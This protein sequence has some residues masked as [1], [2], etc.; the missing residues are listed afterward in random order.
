MSEG[1]NLNE[2]AEADLSNCGSPGEIAQKEAW[3]P[4]AWAV[5]VAHRI[6]DLSRPLD[7]QR[8]RLA[9]LVACGGRADRATSES[10]GQHFTVLEALFQRFTIEALRVVE[11]GGHKAPEHSEA[12]MRSALKAQRAALAC[13]S[14]LKSLRSDDVPTKP[15]NSDEGCRGY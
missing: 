15:A 11:K 8:E 5:A 14:A 6:R 3:E 4:D 13:L 7:A 12:F 10:I 1:A 9:A 2:P